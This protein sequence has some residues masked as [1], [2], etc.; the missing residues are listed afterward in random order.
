MVWVPRRLPIQVVP[1]HVLSMNLLMRWRLGGL[2]RLGSEVVGG[3]S[4]RWWAL[5]LLEDGDGI[6][7]RCLMG[8]LCLKRG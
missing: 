3:G 4:P 5:V 8:G 1:I 2:V 6:C 7:P